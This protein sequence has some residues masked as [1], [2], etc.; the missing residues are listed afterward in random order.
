MVVIGQDNPEA[1]EPMREMLIEGL[2]FESGVPTLIVPFISK[3]DFKVNK[4]TV[5]WDAVQQLLVQSMRRYQ[6][7]KWLSRS[8]SLL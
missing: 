6:F 8:P 4:V 2:L 7:W 1:P 3:G 5:A